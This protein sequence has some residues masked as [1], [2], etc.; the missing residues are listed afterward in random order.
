MVGT[1]VAVKSFLAVCGDS[2]LSFL[3]HKAAAR[4][5]LANDFQQDSVHII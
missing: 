1:T 3:R 4:P 5:L 2:S